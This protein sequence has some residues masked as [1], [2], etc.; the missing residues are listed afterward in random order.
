MIH[1]DK[2]YNKKL[3]CSDNI[4]KLENKKIH[5]NDLQNLDGTMLHNN[6]FQNLSEIFILQKVVRNNNFHTLQKVIHYNN[7]PKNHQEHK[8]GICVV[9]LV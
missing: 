7:F 8:C 4:E 3:F 1:D 5:N 9:Y 6:N 2:I